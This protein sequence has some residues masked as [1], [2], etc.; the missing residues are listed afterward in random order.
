MELYIIKNE[1]FQFT[2][3]DKN[4]AQENVN[5]IFNTKIVDL[6]ES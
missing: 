4:C 1:G 2:V 3:F 5:V 6:D